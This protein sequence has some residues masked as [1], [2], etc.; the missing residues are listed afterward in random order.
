MRGIILAGGSGT[1]LHPI[2]LGISKQLMPIYD[3]PMVYYPLSTLMLAG[4]RDILV[5]TTP[6]DAESFERLLGDGS[7]YGVSI[8]FARQSSPEG[9]AQAFKIGERFIGTDS[10][11]LVLGDNLL[12]GPG[13]GRQLRRF[14]DI[15]GGAIFAYWVANPSAYGVVEFNSNGRA[16]SLEEKP[17]NPKSHYAVPGLYFY[18]NDVIAIARELTPSARG[19]YEI[20]DVNRVYLNQDKLNVEVLPRG[21]AWLDTGTFDQMTDAVEYVRTIERR[22]GLRIGVPEEIGWRQGFLSDDDLRR[23]ASSLMKSGYGGYLLELLERG[24]DE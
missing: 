3:K 24:R 11:S 14:G 12:Y 15:E 20:T 5:I 18:D 22:T 10:V 17:A 8:Q 1:R 4:I 2:T 13:L 23:R 21:T 6:H 9:L 19:E 16:V 7:A